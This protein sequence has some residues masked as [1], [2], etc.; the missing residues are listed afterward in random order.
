MH[1][2]HSLC[3]VFFTQLLQNGGLAGIV[4]AKHQDSSFFLALL[5]FSQQRQKTHIATNTER[6]AGTREERTSINPT[7]VSAEARVNPLQ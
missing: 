3:Y 4:Q 7:L 6:E 5:E 2:R 1:A